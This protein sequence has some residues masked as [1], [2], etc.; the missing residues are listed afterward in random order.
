M[1]ATM[2]HLEVDEMAM[3]LNMRN[4]KSEE[5][6]TMLLPDLQ[7]LTGPNGREWWKQLGIEQEAKRQKKTEAAA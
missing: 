1:H 6:P 3:K 2:A 7:W 4:K 5:L